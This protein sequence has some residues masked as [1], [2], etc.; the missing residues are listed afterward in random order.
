MGELLQ[1]G[2]VKKR[3]GAVDSITGVRLRRWVARQVQSQRCKGGTY[4]L[5]HLRAFRARTFDCAGRD[6]SVGGRREVMSESRMR[7]IRCPVVCPVKVAVQQETN[8]RGRSQSP[9]V[10]G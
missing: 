5:S 3:T 10:F 7:E 6:A 2:T 8:L 4:P 9:V 1:V